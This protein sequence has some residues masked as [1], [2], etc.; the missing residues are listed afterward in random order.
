VMFTG[1]PLMFRAMAATCGPERFDADVLSSWIFEAF[2]P[3][4]ARASAGSPLAAAAVEFVSRW[5]VE[6]F[7]ESV[8]ILA[9]YLPRGMVPLAFASCSSFFWA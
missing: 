9:R 3:F 7:A 8:A 5:S 4:A 6:I 2:T 1:G